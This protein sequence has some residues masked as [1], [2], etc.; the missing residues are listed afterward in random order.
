MSKKPARRIFT[1]HERKQIKA[2]NKSWYHS[3]F[4]GGLGQHARAAAKHS[5]G[6]KR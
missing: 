2:A 6:V 1:I 3:E 4:K 5:K